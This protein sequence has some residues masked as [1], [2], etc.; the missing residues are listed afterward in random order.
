MP[1]LLIVQVESFKQFL[2]EDVP[3]HKRKDEGLQ[4]VFNEVFPIE[5]IHGKYSLEF[6]KYRIGPPK[7]TVEE[8]KKKNL[9]YSVP[10][11][12]TLKL[13]QKDPKSGELENTIEQEVYLCDL[14]YMTPKGTFIINGVERVVVNQLHRSPGVYFEIESKEPA[15]FRALL[16]PY[17]GPWIDFS[18]DG[19][20]VLGITISKRRK[21]PITRLLRAFGHKTSGEI[22][23][24]LFPPSKKKLSELVPDEFVAVDDIVDPKTGE[25]LVES[26]GKLT[27]E[28][29]ENLKSHGI[30]EVEVYDTRDP[31]VEVLLTTLR[32]DRI[33][34]EKGALGNIYRT[35]RYT[36]P[37]DEKEAREYIHN[38]FFSRAR[39]YLARVGRYK[40]N[41]RLGLNID[42]E[43]HTLTMDDFL[44]IVRKLLDL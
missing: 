24:I 19:S 36:P 20:K 34:D 13:H 3:P 1:H 11:W 17:R 21:I 5:D 16:V 28:V 37:K 8:A 27:D 26:T 31:R 2:Q 35:L 44:A 42:P 6:V 22:L 14:P 9:T 10:M 23:K 15:V 40:L 7:Y 33:K 12:V 32:Q 4:S 39:F 30:E 18:I 29:I 43:V 41:W 25:L 38:F